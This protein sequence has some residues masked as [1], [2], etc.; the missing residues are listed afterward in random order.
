V[1]S[2]EQKY[3]LNINKDLGDTYYSGLCCDKN[4]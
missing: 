2:L 3:G 1:T 4:C